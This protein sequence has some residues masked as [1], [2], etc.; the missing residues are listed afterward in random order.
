LILYKLFQLKNLKY[1][2][3][4]LR[5][6]IPGDFRDAGVHM[7]N[8][9]LTRFEESVF[10]PMLQQMAYGNGFIETAYDAASMI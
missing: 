6:K 1:T 8:N 9:N 10:G 3:Q 4:F 5:L 7:Y 2:D